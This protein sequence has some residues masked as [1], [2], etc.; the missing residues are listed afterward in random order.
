MLL[1]MVFEVWQYISRVNGSVEIANTVWKLSWN[2]GFEELHFI[3]LFSIYFVFEKGMKKKKKK[4]ID[5]SFAD[6]QTFV[7]FFKK[8]LFSLNG[9]RLANR[10][11]GG[12]TKKQ[13][14]GSFMSQWLGEVPN[15]IILEGVTMGLACV[16][17]YNEVE[18]DDEEEKREKEGGNYK[19]KKKK[20]RK[21][22]FGVWWHNISLR[23]P[24]SFIFKT[25]NAQDKRP[26]LRV[27]V[28]S[29]TQL[30]FSLKST[31]TWKPECA[32]RKPA[33]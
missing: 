27:Q 16:E 20:K 26:W 2:K 25:R 10:W 33:N 22:T 31:F 7:S 32:P 29:S 8:N 18:D 5:C 19:K 9:R 23:T 24:L 15:P 30:P 21:L 12:M 28:G 6:I 4:T 13:R 11:R 17:S 14:S 3:F 1:L